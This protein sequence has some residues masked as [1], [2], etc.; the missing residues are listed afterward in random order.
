[1][2]STL[3]TAGAPGPLDTTRRFVRPRGA[4][5]KGFIEFEFAIGEPELFVE[6]ILTPEA[7]AEF[8]EANQVEVLPPAA[9]SDTPGDWD[10][11]LS[12]ATAHPFKSTDA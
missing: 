3:D 1:M 9:P 10:W 6:L 2:R 4:R 8:C 5:G 11:R 7:Y 12:D